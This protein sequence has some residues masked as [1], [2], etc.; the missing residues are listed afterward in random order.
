[1]N[2]L[3]I[4]NMFWFKKR[5]RLK[6]LALI[7]TFSKMARYFLLHG[8]WPCDNQDRSSR[9]YFP[10]VQGLNI[11]GTTTLACIALANLFGVV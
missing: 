7:K 4:K 2:W 5:L 6:Q 8:N 9:L 3:A 1:V 10:T 11:C